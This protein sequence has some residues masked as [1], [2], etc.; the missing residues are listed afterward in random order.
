MNSPKQLWSN[1]WGPQVIGGRYYCA[2]WR[3]EYSVVAM[4][5]F[6]ITC[7]QLTAGCFPEQIGKVWSHRT[8]WDWHRD[9]VISQPR[10]LDCYLCH[11]PV[12]RGH[13]EYR[14]GH[15]IRTHL[16]CPPKKLWKPSV[17]QLERAQ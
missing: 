14:Q 4:D 8:A 17:A 3:Y 11:Q 5:E 13:P 1:H 15:I 10:E 16:T 2:Y 6:T 7:Q 12:W 9:R